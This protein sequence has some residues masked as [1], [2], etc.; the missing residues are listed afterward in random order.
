MK[1]FI[2][3]ALLWFST[4]CLSQKVI[5][6]EHPTTGNIQLTENLSIPTINSGYTLWLPEKEVKGMVVF[7]N[8]RRDTL[9]SELVINY[10]LW[11]QLAVLYVTTDNRF[12]F[13]FEEEKMQEVENYLHEVIETYRI[14]KDN[15]LYCGM[16]LAGTRALK[17]AMYGQSDFSRHRIIPKAIAICDAPLDMIRFYR[18][19]LKARELNFIPITGNEG[20]WVSNYLEKNLGGPL[21]QKLDAYLQYSP[22]SYFD[23]GGP[24]LEVFKN[25]AIRAYT[26]PD[27][28][29][30]IDTRR[31]DY[32]GMNAIDMAGFV[33]ELK[34]LG[35]TCLLY[36][37]PSPRD[38][39]ESRM[40]SSA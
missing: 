11:N 5:N 34:I 32:Y 30:W 21:F 17:L 38:Q 36:T 8:P 23:D 22:Y 9:N 26:E 28:N 35:N 33:N 27:V 3:I 39:R 19:M 37:S 6:I 15:L 1:Y 4:F 14:P 16:S 13:F 2:T 25:I 18:E 24:N 29:W 12:E 10:S 7:L 31:K 20:K 40:P